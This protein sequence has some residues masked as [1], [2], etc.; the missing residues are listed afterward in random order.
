VEGYQQAALELA[1]AAARSLVV[2]QS[3]VVIR[4]LVVVQSLVVVRIPVV[5]KENPVAAEDTRRRSFGVVLPDER[6]GVGR[7]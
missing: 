6:V 2:V 7:P 4:S 3:L 5:V 1:V